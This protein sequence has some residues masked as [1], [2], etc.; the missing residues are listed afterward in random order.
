M[1]ASPHGPIRPHPDYGGHRIPR[2][3]DLGPFR[4]TMLTEANLDEDMA[5]IE[6][7]QTALE[8]IFGS[9]WPHGLTREA[10]HADLVRHRREF[11]AGCA[12]AWAIRDSAGAYLGC[13]YVRPYFDR[14]S[15]ARVAHWLRASATAHGPAFQALFHHWL[16]GPPWPPMEMTI[17]AHP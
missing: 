17:I 5:A 11:D 4:L 10:D 2:E 7:S 1:A 13:A 8:G 16:R 12:F 14:S 9:R 3:I 6:E 15:S